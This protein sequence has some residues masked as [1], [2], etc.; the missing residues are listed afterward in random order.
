MDDPHAAIVDGSRYTFRVSAPALE[1]PWWLLPPGRLNPLW[2]VAV[3]G[4][5]LAVDYATQLY[6]QAPVV[7]AIPV[8]IAAWYSGRRPALAQ[9]IVTPIVHL[10]FQLTLWP[11][12]G[13]LGLLLFQTTIRT[14]AIVVMALWFARLSKHERDLHRHVQT[15]EGLL[16][17]CAFCKSIRNDAGEWERLEKFISTRSDAQFS[18]GFC[19]SCQK[20]HYPDL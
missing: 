6:N 17:I 12:T 9:A 18:H 20:T 7:Y 2:W 4:I 13:S 16:P 11:Q 1:R 10:A 19:P 3:T 8:T 5:L 14:S 15:L